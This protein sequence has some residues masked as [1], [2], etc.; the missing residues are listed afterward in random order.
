MTRFAPEI[1]VKLTNLK[2]TPKLG[3]LVGVTLLGL[4]VAGGLAGYLMQQE[5]LT[6]RMDQVKA[7]VD[8]GR[9]MA[10]GLQ[11]EVEAGKLTKE[12]ALAEFGR[13]ANTLTFDRGTGYLF[14]TSYDGIT[15]LSPEPQQIGTNRMDVVTAGRKISRE[16]MEGTRANG[17]VLL[18]YDYV[19][20]GQDVPVRKIGY[21]VA[22]PFFNM[23][24]GTGAYLDDL[25]AKLKPIAW[26]L[27]LAILGIAVIGGAIAWLI[28]RSIS[29]PLGDLGARMQALADGS[30]EGDI[31]G[32]GRGDDRRCGVAERLQQ[33]RHGRG[34]RRR[35][36]Q[37]GCRNRP[38]GLA[39]ERDRQQGGRRRRAHQHHRSG[40]VDRRREDR[41]GGQA[42]PQHRRADQP[43][44]A[45][46]DHRSG[47][48]R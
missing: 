16:L 47:A 10:A 36:F 42:D 6:A 35:A 20:P 19:R 15:V 27:A 30:L 29:K 4:C 9:N 25:D 13:R 14:G 12:A 33:C 17:S 1:P 3:I 8:M 28:G 34:R 2:I 26:T 32:L 5:M 37:F 46:R 11:K 48:R 31:P 45:E 24:I 41:R 21:A 44:G 43:A 22:I 7:M 40:L 38:A 18:T 39:L 23:Y